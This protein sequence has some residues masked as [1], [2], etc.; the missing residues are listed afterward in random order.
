MP[1]AA[2]DDEVKRLASAIAAD[3]KALN[4]AVGGG[5]VTITPSDVLPPVGSWLP[6]QCVAGTLGLAPT[7]GEL[8]CLP[9]RIAR[10]TRIDAL[11]I[12][13]TT[14]QAGGTTSVRVGLWP[15]NADCTA[16]DPSNLIASATVDPTTGGGKTGTVT[17]VT[18]SPGT[19]WTGLLYTQS[20]A[21]TTVPQ[22]LS[23][24]N[25]VGIWAPGAGAVG[26]SIKQT[27]LSDFPTSGTFVGDSGSNAPV[28][29]LRRA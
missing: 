16:P 10:Q 19:Y 3:I 26:R 28:V 22:F 2:S 17:A 13:V 21:P 7:A 25:V 4:D 11:G 24:S 6:P 12:Y 23:A 27:G 15:S 20:A 9:V 29:S 5:A 1:G 14:A 18:L 8:K